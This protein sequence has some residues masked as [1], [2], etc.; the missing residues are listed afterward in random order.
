MG[1]VR[2]PQFELEQPFASAVVLEKAHAW[3][4]GGL[5]LQSFTSVQVLGLSERK[6]AYSHVACCQLPEQKA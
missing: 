1:L 5:S 6:C 3:E 4:Y 2:N